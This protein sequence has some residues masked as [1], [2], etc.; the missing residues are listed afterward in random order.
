MAHSLSAKKRVRQNESRRALN[1]WRRTRYRDA[2]KDY[3]E[4]ILHGSVEDCQA[5]LRGLYKLLDQVAATGTLHKN[6]AA[7]Y[8]SRLSAAL[9]RK[10]AP[11]GAAA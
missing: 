10:K 9:A 3:R 8:K 4:A 6:T 2:I 5:K 11:A 1:R 7:R